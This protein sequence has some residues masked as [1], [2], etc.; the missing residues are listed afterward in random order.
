MNM[1]IRELLKLVEEW[2][3]GLTRGERSALVDA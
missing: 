1:G 3:G 2:N